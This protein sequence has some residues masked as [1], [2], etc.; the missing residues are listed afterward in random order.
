MN[1]RYLLVP[2]TLLLFHFAT[3]EAFD[4]RRISSFL[5]KSILKKSDFQWKGPAGGSYHLAD[6]NGKPDPTLLWRKFL[7]KVTNK[8]QPLLHHVNWKEGKVQDEKRRDEFPCPL[9]DTRS[10]VQPVNIHQLRPGD[11]DV[12]AAIGDSLSSGNGAMSATALGAYTEFRGMSFSGGG[13]QDWTTLL[14]LPNILKVFNPNLYGFATEN[15]L[16]RDLAA[17][18]NVAEPNA[19]SRD[20]V[21]QV[22]ILIQRMQQDPRVDMPRHWKLLTILIGSNDFCMDMCHQDNMFKFLKQH[23]E[24]LRKALTLLRNNVPRLMV[25]LIPAPNLVY[26]QQ[27]LKTL[28]G[29]YKIPLGLACSCLVNRF[30]TPEYLQKASELISRWQAVD[31]HIAGLAEFHTSDF[32]VIYQQFMANLTI[33]HL[34][35]GFIDLR[36]FGKD[37]IHFSQ[38]GHAAVANLLWNNMVQ[39]SGQEDLDLRQPFENFE[40]P[41]AERPYI[42]T[43]KNKNE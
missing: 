18:L 39:G 7:L 14:T 8:F 3:N 31:E 1:L 38:F 4:Q 2:F 24:D 34:S 42:L 28:P 41:T 17:H 9:N 25:N 10:P 5:D 40:C 11:I 33:P 15:V 21:Q 30:Y 32:T 13:M 23:E 26:L 36:Y 35:N 27:Q 6:W 16:S 37:G 22:Q 19:L 20:L 43:M 12:V 29:I